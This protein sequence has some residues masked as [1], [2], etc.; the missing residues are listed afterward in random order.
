[1]TLSQML[2]NGEQ[3]DSDGVFCIMSRQAC[4]EAAEVIEGQQ[5]QI[6]TLQDQ[7]DALLSE[8]TL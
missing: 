7:I 6:D 8:E 3:C 5:A 4:H 1:M 2:R